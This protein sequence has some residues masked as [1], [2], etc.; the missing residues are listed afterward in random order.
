MIDADV[1]RENA[2]SRPRVD[3]G[4]LAVGVA[5]VLVIVA[6]VFP[7]FWMVAA[8]LKTRADV[9]AFPPVWIFTPTLDHYREALSRVDVARS[10]FN[11]LIIGTASTFLALLVGTPAAYA[12]ARWEWRGKREVW[13]WI[14]SNRFMS[15]VVLALP[16]FL[17]ARALGVLDN[18]WTLV[19]IYLTFNVPLVVW[20]VMDQFRAVPRELDEAAVVDGAT[21]FIAFFR[22]VLPL[23]TPGVV[24][25]AI[26]CFIF[27]WNE[28][29]YALVLTRAAARTAPVAA[30]AFMS[31][32]DLPW[33]EI[34]ATGTMIVL[35]V[36]VFALLVSRHLVRGL[37]LGA[38]K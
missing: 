38:I 22:V 19:A 1:V 2:V 26:L 9:L 25:S 24:V 28:L 30:T 7:F 8:S 21:P 36:I 12:L 32:Y 3:L 16:F 17:L 5:L 15:P 27:S 13:F 33:G 10:L 23:A 35:P 34:M 4:H 37:T 18:P 11:S 20:I 6:T 29:L 31:G 14:I